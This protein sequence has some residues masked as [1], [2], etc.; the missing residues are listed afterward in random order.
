MDVAAYLTLTAWAV[1]LIGVSILMLVRPQA[2]LG[3]LGMFA[4]TNFINYLEL[5]SRLTVGLAFV[6]YAKSMPYPVIFSVFGWFLAASAAI[7]MLTPRRW[8]AKY[9][10]YW[11]NRLQPWQIQLAAPFSLIAGVLII[12]VIN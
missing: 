1:W 6:W 4:S 8:H 2:A 12:S 5:I 7:L 10:V 3:Y 11:A 9:A